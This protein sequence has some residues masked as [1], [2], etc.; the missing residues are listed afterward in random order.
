M[1]T[2]L[3][4]TSWISGTTLLRIGISSVFLW[5]GCQQFLSPEM[6][7]GF[8]PQW[9]L[10]IS[11]IGP[12]T[13]VHLNG[14]LELVF[15]TALMFGLFTRASALVLGLHMAHITI[16]VGYDSIGVR[17]F[18][19]AIAALSVFFNGA[20]SLTIDHTILF[21]PEVG[22]EIESGVKQTKPFK[23]VPGEFHI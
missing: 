10:D 22:E 7:I 20:D 13:L 12:V 8:I 19:L 2:K 1:E 3:R 6:W 11:P 16:M 9:V 5:F 15:G 17:D 4:I 14:A 23:Y 21:P 18:G